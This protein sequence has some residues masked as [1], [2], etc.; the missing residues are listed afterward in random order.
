MTTYYLQEGNTDSSVRDYKDNSRTL[1][2]DERMFLD[3]HKHKDAR[4]VVTVEAE[5]WID[6]RYQI[7]NV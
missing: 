6:A 1:L 5:S 3:D 7:G 2:P 4:T